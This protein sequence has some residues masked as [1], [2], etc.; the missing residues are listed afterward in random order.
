[1]K[2]N[3]EA[4]LYWAAAN[5]T[6]SWYLAL[7]I[8]VLPIFVRFLIAAFWGHVSEGVKNNIELYNSVKDTIKPVFYAASGWVSWVI[9]FAHIYHLHDID[10]ASKSQAQYTNVVSD[11]LLSR[12]MITTE[13]L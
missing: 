12:A 2:D 9:I 4:W 13:L 6:I 8:D 3:V 1:M 11:D 5:L 10:D 7:C